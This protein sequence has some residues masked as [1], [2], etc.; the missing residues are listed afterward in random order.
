MSA[1]GV[2]QLAQEADEPVNAELRAVGVH[3]LHGA[4]AEQE[5][6]IAVADRYVCISS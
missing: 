4:V 6:P 5:Q 1:C 3:D 2:A